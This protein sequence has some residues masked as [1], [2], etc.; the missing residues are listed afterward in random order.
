[1]LKLRKGDSPQDV[2]IKRMS[3]HAL[4]G[5]QNFQREVKEEQ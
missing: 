5:L 3:P 2:A 4:Q 1:M